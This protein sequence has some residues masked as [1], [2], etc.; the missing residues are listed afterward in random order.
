[1]LLVYTSLQV[2]MLPSQWRVMV[3]QNRQ[4]SSCSPRLHVERAS[5]AFLKPFPLTISCSVNI[6]LLGHQTSSLPWL[7]NQKTPMS[8]LKPPILNLLW[9]LVG[10]LHGPL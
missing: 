10:A 8:S 4:P 1:M 3:F 7:G 5:L 9:V 6:W 2:I